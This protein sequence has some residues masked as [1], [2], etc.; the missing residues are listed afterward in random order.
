MYFMSHFNKILSSYYTFPILYKRL[1]SSKKKIISSDFASKKKMA[2]RII[3]WLMTTSFVYGCD[4]SQECIYY[5]GEFVECPGEEACVYSGRV[6]QVNC[7]IEK[8]Q[9]WFPIEELRIKGNCPIENFKKFCQDGVKT[10]L[11]LDS[12]EKFTCTEMSSSATLPS[13]ARSGTSFDVEEHTDIREHTIST[14]YY[15]SS[16]RMQSSNTATSTDLSNPSSSPSTFAYQKMTTHPALHSS[17][18]ELLTTSPHTYSITTFTPHTA[19]YQRKTIIPSS[20]I[21]SLPLQSTLYSSRIHS[22]RF[23]DHT[24]EKYTTPSSP[25]TSTTEDIST[26]EGVTTRGS[27]AEDTRGTKHGRFIYLYIL[28]AIP[29]FILAC[30][31]ILKYKQRKK[32]IIH[33]LNL[34]TIT[35]YENDNESDEETV[36]EYV[37]TV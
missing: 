31:C 21:S 8:I 10:I 24:T 23:N 15:V 29:I 28:L 9:L 25:N 22:T 5:L 11:M 4:L 7:W 1:Y 30:V 34:E 6:V 26:T 12:D 2:L 37:S 33:D 27:S 19:T 20:V 32:N 14:D 3:L 35:N 17:T 16:T 36:Y 18:P 13:S